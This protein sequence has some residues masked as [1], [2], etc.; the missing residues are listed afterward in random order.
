M[1]PSGL[2]IDCRLATC[3]TRRCPS[4]VNATTDGVTRPPSALGTTSARPPSIAATTE[5][6]VPRS[7]PTA[8]AMSTSSTRTRYA[9]PDGHGPPR[10][11]QRRPPDR[12]VGGALVGLARIPC[13]LAQRRTAAIAGGL[14]P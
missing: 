1:V 14:A 13:T 7:I 12:Q 6:V 11:A 10:S 2:R 3:P 4:G 5:F 8:F 9:A